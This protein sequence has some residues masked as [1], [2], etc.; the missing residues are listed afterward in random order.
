MLEPRE[1]RTDSLMLAK[2]L[3]SKDLSNTYFLM[4]K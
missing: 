3:A 1:L 2:I 4:A